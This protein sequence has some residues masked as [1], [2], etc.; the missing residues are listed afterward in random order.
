ML[1]KMYRVSKWTTWSCR[2]KS[3]CDKKKIQQSQK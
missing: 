3:V 2:D 1:N